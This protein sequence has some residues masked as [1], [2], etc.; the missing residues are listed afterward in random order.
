[1]SKRY[2]FS[3][4][5]HLFYLSSLLLISTL[6]STYFWELFGPNFIPSVSFFLSLSLSWTL[7]TV[8]IHRERNIVLL[9]A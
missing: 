6:S 5:F 8:E 1:M 9:V 7:P 4:R 3:P 2:F